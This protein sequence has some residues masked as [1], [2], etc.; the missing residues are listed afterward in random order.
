M[1]EFIKA[2]RLEVTHN[3]HETMSKRLNAPPIDREM[4][5]RIGPAT[6]ETAEGYVI[7]ILRHIART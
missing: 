3:A 2:V 4:W 6:L 7:G 5:V 1:S